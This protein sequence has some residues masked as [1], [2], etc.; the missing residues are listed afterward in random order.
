MRL[1]KRVVAVFLGLAVTV[2]FAGPALASRADGICGG[3][4]SHWDPVLH[5]CVPD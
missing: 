3:V 2:G 1:R 5:E 4:G